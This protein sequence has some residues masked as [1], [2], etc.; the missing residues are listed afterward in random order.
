MHKKIVF[1]EINQNKISLAN[2]IESKDKYT[3]TDKET[4]NLDKL[5]FFDNKLFNNSNLLQIIQEYLSKNNIK[6]GRSI[7]SVP[8]NVSE[9]TILQIA[10]CLSKTCLKIEKIISLNNSEETFNVIENFILKKDLRK[11]TNHWQVFLPPKN[12]NPKKWIAIS[13]SI[14]I[15]EF[16]LLTTTSIKK[17]INHKNL[18]KQNLSLKQ[19]VKGL[20]SELNKNNNTSKSNTMLQ[21]KINKLYAK[22]NQQFLNS[23]LDIANHLPPNAK[24]NKIK[25]MS[26]N[27]EIEENKQTSN[28]K[29]KAAISLE[30][31]SKHQQNLINFVKKLNNSKVF[32]KASLKN[33]NRI[34]EKISHKIYNFNIHAKLNPL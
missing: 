34:K 30:G 29:N 28:K 33:I 4:T 24:L 27:K 14:L 6:K 21:K 17:H 16:S 13:L 3:L 11:T 31:K 12:Q 32:S 1:I 26:Q 18:K 25:L 8:S 15:I 22:Q 9:I 19:K 23:L 20:K 2:L 5:T 7:L 10:L